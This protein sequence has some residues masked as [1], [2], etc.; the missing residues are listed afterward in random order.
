[1]P[2]LATALLGGAILSLLP[3]TAALAAPLPATP[4]TVLRLSVTHGPHVSPSG[5]TSSYRALLLTCD[6]AG[7]GHPKAVRACA[8]LAD[9]DGA[10][11]RDVQDVICTTEYAP[12]TVEAS[13][14]WHGRLVGFRKTY[15]NDCDM[16]AHTGSLFDF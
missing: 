11:E 2:H 3:F 4:G 12:V 8:Q 13:G 16:A 10:F 1:M 6:P 9:S 15:G 14:R 5:A 7:D